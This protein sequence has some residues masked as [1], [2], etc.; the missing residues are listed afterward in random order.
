MAVEL[1]QQREMT[2]VV[3]K[4]GAEVESESLDVADHRLVVRHAF[5]NLLHGSLGLERHD[6][7]EHCR[8]SL[9]HL[10]VEA[11]RVQLQIHAAGV[12]LGVKPCQGRI[13]GIDSDGNRVFHCVQARKQ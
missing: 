1:D 6:A 7:A 3:R 8:S 4:H 12:N 2:G 11:L 9:Q 13:Q 5:V 10:E